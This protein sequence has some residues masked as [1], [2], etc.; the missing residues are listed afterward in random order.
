MK[1]WKAILLHGLFIFGGEISNETNN[2]N[3]E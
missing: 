2:N 3:S 1:W